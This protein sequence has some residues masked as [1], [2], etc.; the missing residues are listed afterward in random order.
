MDQIVNKRS[1]DGWL[2][3]KLVC[4]SPILDVVEMAIIL[5]PKVNVNRCVIPGRW[6]R[7]WDSICHPLMICHSHFHRDR[8]VAVWHT[9]EH[10]SVE[11]LVVL[12][13][14][15]RLVVVHHQND[16]ENPLKIVGKNRHQNAR[17]EKVSDHQPIEDPRH[18]AETIVRHLPVVIDHRLQGVVLIP[19]AIGDHQTED[20]ILQE[21]DDHLLEIKDNGIHLVI[22]VGDPRHHEEMEYHLLG[23]ETVFLTVE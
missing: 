7:S 15:L 5:K 3:G 12:K 13:A 22:D 11:S 2:L 23:L 20:G 4:K 19:M 8:L 14:V 10:L 17:V 1:C 16:Q 21:M 6:S 9:Q 18:L